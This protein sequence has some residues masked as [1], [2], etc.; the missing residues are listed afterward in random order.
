MIDGTPGEPW[1]NDTQKVRYQ[2]I[3]SLH[4]TCGVCLQYH[5]KIGPWWPIPIHY[6]CRC[7]QVPVLPGAVAREPFTDY[8]KL[9]EDMPHDQQ[10]AAIGASNYKLLQAGVVKWDDIV[11]PS[12]VR[13]F[14][15]V[16]SLRRLSIDRM[17][18]AGV[19]PRIAERAYETVHTPEHEHIERHRREL[20]ERLT[21]AGLAH[22]PLVNELSRRLAARVGIAE[23]EAAGVKAQK[24]PCTGAATAAELKKLL[25]AAVVT[26]VAMGPKPKQE[27]APLKKAAPVQAVEPAAIEPETFHRD[28]M[29]AADRAPQWRESGSVF[30]HKVYEELI[31]DPRYANLT[32]DQ[33]KQLLVEDPEMRMKMRRADM[34][35][36]MNPADVAVSQ[37]EM[38]AGERVMATFNFIKLPRH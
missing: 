20:A 30:I 4:N 28:V 14:I 9:L 16:V 3:A 23:Q 38:T 32:L 10:V 13:D 17:V 11:T 25:R 37:T 26:R 27:P 18:R 15:E 34:V 33:F 24:L 12:R 2:F 36:A 22:Q 31:R 6:G 35:Q 7:H 5:L 8:R 1:T 29:A 19:R 21:R